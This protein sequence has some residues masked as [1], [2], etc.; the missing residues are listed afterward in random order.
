MICDARTN[1]FGRGVATRSAPALL[2]RSTSGRPLSPITA[3]G[4]LLERLA[5]RG[6]CWSSNGGGVIEKIAATDTART[7]KRIGATDVVTGWT[8]AAHRHPLPRPPQLGG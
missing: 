2:I 6:F 5:D 7:A 1:K 8:G 3:V 4:H